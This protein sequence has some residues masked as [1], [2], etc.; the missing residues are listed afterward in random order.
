M[1]KIENFVFQWAPLYGL[2]LGLS[3]TRLIRQKRHFQPQLRQ[4]SV[5][6]TSVG[7][8]SQ[9]PK[10]NNR[11]FLI[12]KKRMVR[13]TGVGGQIRRQAYLRLGQFWERERQRG[14]IEI[15]RDTETWKQRDI[16]TI[17]IPSKAGQPLQYLK[18][19]DPIVS[20]FLYNN[21]SYS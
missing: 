12:W 13:E 6:Q 16:E 18:K 7:Q 19:I 4:M 20:Q 5:G 1:K 17:K 8:Q 9:H 11:E 15:Q 14:E 2:T 10:I 3:D 21:Y